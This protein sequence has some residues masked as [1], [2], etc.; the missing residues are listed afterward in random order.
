MA[1][2]PFSISPGCPLRPPTSSIKPSLLCPLRSLLIVRSR[3]RTKWVSST[4]TG[5]SGHLGVSMLLE[6]VHESDGSASRTTSRRKNGRVVDDKLPSAQTWIPGTKGRAFDAL[7]TLVRMGTFRVVASATGHWTERRRSTVS[8][9]YW[10]LLR[11]VSKDVTTL[12][13]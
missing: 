10:G 4:S 11:C 2:T 7:E 12:V 8:F 1:L 6:R 13:L 5:V 3:L 9:Q